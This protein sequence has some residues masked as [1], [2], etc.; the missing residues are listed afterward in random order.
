MIMVIFNFELYYTLMHVLYCHEHKIC[1]H[2]HTHNTHTQTIQIHTTMLVHTSI[3]RWMCILSWAYHLHVHTHT[4]RN[5]LSCW[6][7][8]THVYTFM[9]T[10]FTYMSTHTHMHTHRLQEHTIMLVHTP[11][12]MCILS[13]AQHLHTYPHTHIHYI[14][15]YTH[16]DPILHTGLHLCPYIPTIFSLADFTQR[17][18]HHARSHTHMP[19]HVYNFISITFACTHTRNTPWCWFTH[20]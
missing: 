7:T 14:R 15:T 8:L 17:I 20:P 19:L 1:I 10:T 3:C 13:S 12:W 5:T 6:F 18:C 2:V 4:N 9:R 16:T 11:L